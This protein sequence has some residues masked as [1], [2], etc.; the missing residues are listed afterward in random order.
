MQEFLWTQILNACNR[1]IVL[2]N[3]FVAKIKILKLKTKNAYLGNFGLKFE[4]NGH[5]WDQRPWICII[6]K[7]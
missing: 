7:K 5:I 3:S 6:G 4:K 2:K 1:K